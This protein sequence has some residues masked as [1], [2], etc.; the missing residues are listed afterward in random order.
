MKGLLVVGLLDVM[1][2]FFLS[3]VSPPSSVVFLIMNITNLAS[4]SQI[5]R[6]QS[7]IMLG[8]SITSFVCFLVLHRKELVNVEGFVWK[9]P[10]IL[11]KKFFNLWSCFSKKNN[12]EKR[13][14]RTV[15]CSECQ[16]EYIKDYLERG[17]SNLSNGISVLFWFRRTG[18]SHL[19][20]KIFCFSLSYRLSG[21]FSNKS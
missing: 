15:L 17:I 14:I 4:A 12:R 19:G 18:Y 5:F 16:Y 1:V 6:K 3:D 8:I 13:W 10:L 20:K 9:S 7:T 21:N 2:V 11:W